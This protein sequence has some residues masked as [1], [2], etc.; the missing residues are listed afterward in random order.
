MRGGFL[1]LLLALCAPTPAFA[2]TRAAPNQLDIRIC[3]ESGR[4]AFTAVIYRTGGVWRSEGWF[5]VDNGECAT[6]VTSDNLR[7]YAF[8]EEVGNLDYLWGGSFPHCVIR[9]G[10]YDEAV[11]PEVRQCRAEQDSVQFVEWLAD[12]FGTFTWTLDP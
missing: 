10:P 1:L 9:P 8:A 3:N 7:F 6:I 5:R 4:N 2:Q 11:D 12:E